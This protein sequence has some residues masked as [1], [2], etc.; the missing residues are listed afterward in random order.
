MSCL[1]STTCDT[2]L[3]SIQAEERSSSD[4][5]TFLSNKTLFGYVHN[6]LIPISLPNSTVVYATPPFR[7]T[8]DYVRWKKIQSQLYSVPN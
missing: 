3:N 7:S 1:K 5:S 2:H 6:N 8:R 4:S